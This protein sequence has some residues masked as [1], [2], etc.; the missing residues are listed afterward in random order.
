MRPANGEQM[1]VAASTNSLDSLNT[2]EYDTWARVWSRVCF[3]SLRNLR[4][5]L[6][7]L[8]Q[9]VKGGRAQ[10]CVHS[11][12]TNNQP[13]PA[14]RLRGQQALPQIG[15]KC[16]VGP[17]F[18]KLTLNTMAVRDKNRAPPLP[19]AFDQ[20]DCLQVSGL[21]FVLLK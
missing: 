18:G 13:P 17:L 8:T 14:A 9:L 11:V 20:R 3:V 7:W 16:Q 5:A 19:L 1:P 12:A 2:F 10:L 6:V 4:N 21:C 15:T